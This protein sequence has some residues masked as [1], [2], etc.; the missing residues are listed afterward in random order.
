MKPSQTP[1]VLVCAGD[2][3]RLKELSRLLEAQ[4]RRVTGHLFTA[5]DPDRVARYQLVLIDSGRS[6][7]APALCRRLRARLEDLFVPF[8]FVSEDGPAARLASLEAGADAWLFRP[9]GAAELAAQVT[10]LLRIKEIHDRLLDR[11]AEVN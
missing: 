1:G 9:F 2:E 8:L 4:G 3:A 11:S 5:P 7:K 6:G 10:A